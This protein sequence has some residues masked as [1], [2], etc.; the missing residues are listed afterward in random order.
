MG[1]E[2]NMVLGYGFIVTNKSGITETLLAN[3][4]AD[5]FDFEID[6]SEYDGISNMLTDK[7]GI[8][9]QND[10]YESPVPT[11]FISVNCE[12][13]V[14]MFSNKY[15]EHS[16]KININVNKVTKD[17][18][19]CLDKLHKFFKNNLDLTKDWADIDVSD[20]KPYVYT[21]NS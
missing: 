6:Q 19:K 1:F 5:K 7:M 12:N 8:S 21:Y 14:D 3:Q 15:M 10:F 20:I 17:Q 9:V 2:F 4:I 18:Q 16:G 13:V 11:W